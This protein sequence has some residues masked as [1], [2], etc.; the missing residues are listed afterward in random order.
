MSN[1]PGIGCLVSPTS[2]ASPEPAPAGVFADMAI[3]SITATD[4]NTLEWKLS[5][6]YF[7]AEKQILL[8]YA[9]WVMPREVIEEHGD[10]RDWKNLV[11][12][13]PWMLTD[14]VF[15]SIYN[16]EKNPNYW[17]FDEKY[18][19]NRLPYFDQVRALIMSDEAEIAALRTGKV[20]GVTFGTNELTIDEARNL[21]RTNPEIEMWPY[22]RN[23]FTSF[24]H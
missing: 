6:P 22:A 18:P 14:M 7:D 21:N 15:D 8:N 4:N 24:F 5:E 16:L 17:G 10:M 9:T 11:G 19:E 20:D 13:G 23:S 12:T 3:E 1:S 2:T